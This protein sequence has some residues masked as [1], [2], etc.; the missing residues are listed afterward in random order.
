MAMPVLAT[1]LFVP[2]ARPETVGRARLVERLQSG[3]ESGGRL[4]LVSAP[5]G[6]G[7]TT[8]VSEWLAEATRR[9]PEVR[10]AWLSLDENDNEPTRFF[11]YLF[12]ALQRA[13]VGVGDFD[14][15]QPIEETL[16]TLINQI[17][18]GSGRV[19]L[20]LDDFHLIED[21]A[22]GD[23]LAFLIDNVPSQLRLT[24][25]SRSDPLLPLARLR[26]RGELTELRAAD[27]RFTPEEAASF[28]NQAMG[29]TL[30]PDD[31][32]ALETRT[33]GWI[34]GLQLAALSMRE[35]SDIPAF[36][37]D[38]A[39]SNRF[40]ID[41]LIEEVLHRASHDVREFLCQT[42]ILDRLSGPL[43][44]AVTGQKGGAE[45]LEALDRANLFVV[46]LDDRRQ[47]YRYHHLF[48]D[49]LQSRLLAH[50][51]EYEAALH[52]RASEWL[53]HN[54]APDE[55]V[56]HALAA[57]DYPRAARLIEAAIPGVRK[58][59]QDAQLLRW[60]AQLPEE[61]VG[62]MPVLSVFSAWAHILRGELDGVEPWLVTAERLLASGD[63]D[64]GDG[65]ELRSLPVTMSLYRAAVAQASGDLAGVQTNAQRAS[66]LAAPDDHLGRGAAAGMLGLAAAARGDLEAGVRAFGE[67]ATN[68]RLAGNL[69]DALSTATVVADMLLPLGRLPE[70][71]RAYEDALRI[72]TDE[73][74]A[75]GRGEPPVA[76]LHSGLAELLI[77]AHEL[78]SARDHLA[79]AEALGDHAFSPEHRFRWFV[80]MARLREAEG[81]PDAALDLLASAQRH[82]R[83]GFFPDARPIG[84]MRA[85]ILIEQGRLDEAAAAIDELG[86]TGDDEPAYLSEYGQI[87]R[88]RLLLSQSR[89]G[90]ATELLGRLLTAAEAGGRAAR[91]TEIRELLGGASSAGR[92][93]TAE[94]VGTAG[95]VATATP[96]LLSER[97]LEVLRLLATELSGP[98]I[99][100]QLYVS[101]N[102]MRTHTKHIFDKL[103]VNS[104]PAAVRRGHELNLL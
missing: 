11:T 42:S 70:A 14:P 88:A 16:A 46:P 99:A 63:H 91:V 7:K 67:S 12:A 4:S 95:R 80:S 86:L 9:D 49:V 20:V 40:V 53:E 57:S 97:E 68:L 104:R 79:M 50:G 8:L 73:G 102:T 101:L 34:A 36:I 22:I 6:F 17:A 78:E 103:E 28:L 56:G 25:A 66:D 60:L 24:L 75:D 69:T 98:E 84:A 51:P 72:A 52:V 18:E 89:T 13:G 81:D 41:Y 1:K 3:L 61:T 83:R 58:S 82:Y 10:V 71:I 55:A 31:V 87:T 62:R 45:M 30:S 26:T 100:R 59:R 90:E 23:A 85:R 21:A 35:Q 76:D 38:F 74:L 5:A 77:E 64:S 93:G 48:A 96:E 94:R 32:T 27:L 29:L 19:I 43:C 39:G 47:W 92:V 65:E 15:Q 2:P 33:E 37:A 44:D 54:D